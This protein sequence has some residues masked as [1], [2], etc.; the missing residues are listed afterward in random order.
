[1]NSN[2]TILFLLLLSAGF[3]SCDKSQDF[4]R[5]NT[6]ATG[7][8]YAPVSNNAVLDYTFTPP[9]SIA[10]SSTSATS[11]PAGSTIKAELTFFSQSPIKETLL[12][13]TIG[14]GTKTLIATIPYSPAFSALKGVDTL[15]VPYTVP[16]SA[17]VNTVI[18]LDFE[19]INTNALKVIRTVYVKRT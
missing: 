6:T 8:G 13:N 2:K 19:I 10:T 14:A 3:A 17:A 4:L 16:A 5:D 15:L 12:Y 7:V 18:R 11:Y 9:R 1:M